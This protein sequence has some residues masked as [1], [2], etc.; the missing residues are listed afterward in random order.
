MQILCKFRTC[1]VAEHAAGFRPPVDR[2]KW[3]LPA[4]VVVVAAAAAAA[5]VV[6]SYVAPPDQP[7]S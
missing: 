4:V 6:D 1:S 3:Q 2:W 7:E 5:V